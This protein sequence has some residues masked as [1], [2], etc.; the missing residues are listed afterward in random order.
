M[1]V[2]F[3]SVRCCLSKVG[4]MPEEAFYEVQKIVAGVAILTHQS[5]HQFSVPLNRLRGHV[6]EGATLRVQLDNHGTPN[7]YSAQIDNTKAGK[8]PGTMTEGTDDKGSS[9]DKQP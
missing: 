2:S 1:P 5:K 6:T 3:R 7:W 9:G 8:R 4:T